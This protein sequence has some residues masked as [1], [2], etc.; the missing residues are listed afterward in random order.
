MSSLQIRTDVL[1]RRRTV[2]GIELGPLADAAGISYGH[3]HN[4]LTGRR[5]PSITVVHR[6]AAR[7]SLR[8]D[9]LLADTGTGS[10]EATGSE[11]GDATASAA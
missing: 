5:R 9:E 8:P 11:V 10:E 4:I 3:M 6:L 2:L 7:L 1:N